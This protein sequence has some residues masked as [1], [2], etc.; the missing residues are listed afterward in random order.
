MAMFFIGMLFAYGIFAT[1][2]YM[3]SERDLSKLNKTIKAKRNHPSSGI[4]QINRK[5]G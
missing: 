5:V 2:A 3:D 1:L 4:I